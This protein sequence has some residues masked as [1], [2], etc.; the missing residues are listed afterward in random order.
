MLPFVSKCKRFFITAL[1]L[2]L[3]VA[4][5]ML[6]IRDKENTTLIKQQKITHQDQVARAARLLVQSATQTHPLLALDHVLEAKYIVDRVIST[7]GSVTSAERLLKLKHYSVTELHD[8][9]VQQ[10]INVQDH[11]MTHIINENPKMRLDINQLAGLT[12]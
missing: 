11:I 7:Y 4:T 5:V 6:W 12:V 2:L 10:A 3:T 1:L 8:Q 9:I